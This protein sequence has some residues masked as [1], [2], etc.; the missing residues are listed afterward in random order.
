ME[1]HKIQDLGFP[2]MKTDLQVLCLWDDVIGGSIDEL[3]LDRWNA[4]SQEMLSLNKH[5]I[6]EGVR[7]SGVHKGLQD[8]I[9]KGVRSQGKSEWVRIW[10][11]ECIESKG[12]CM[13]EFNAVFRSCGVSRTAQ[14][15]FESMLQDAD[16]SWSDLDAQALEEAEL[17]FGQSLVTCPT[18]PQK[19]KLVVKMVLMLLWS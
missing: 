11:S 12:F 6:N 16:L 18:V 19:R 15:F 14:S 13:R 4:I 5:R 1:W 17:D 10:K 3:Q 9:W 7:I 8:H 2:S